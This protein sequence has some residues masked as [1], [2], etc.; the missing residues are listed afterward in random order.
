MEALPLVR[1]FPAY[2]KWES[3]GKKMEMVYKQRAYV[4]DVHGMEDKLLMAMVNSSA[5]KGT[6]GIKA[7]ASHGGNGSGGSSGQGSSYSMCGGRR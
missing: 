5:K 4:K 7:I 3:L 1:R 6:A 2:K